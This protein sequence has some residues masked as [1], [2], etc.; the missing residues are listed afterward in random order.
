MREMASKLRLRRPRASLEKKAMLA[1]DNDMVVEE[2]GLEDK[3]GE[4]DNEVEMKD[5]KDEGGQ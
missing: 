1:G 2:K 5:G 4:D 3:D